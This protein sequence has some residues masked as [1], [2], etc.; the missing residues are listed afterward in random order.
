MSVTRLHCPHCGVDFVDA[1][2]ELRR[3]D[4]VMCPACHAVNAV[5]ADDAIAGRVETAEDI[6]V[7]HRAEDD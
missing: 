1:R 7:R 5:S 2:A 6:P 3:G 4:D